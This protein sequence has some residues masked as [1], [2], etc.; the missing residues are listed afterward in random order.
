M[1][2]PSVECILPNIDNSI[3]ILYTFQVVLTLSTVT[4]AVYCYQSITVKLR[5]RPFKVYQFESNE[6]I[7]KAVQAVCFTLQT[8]KNKFLV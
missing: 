4:N 6:L 1:T 3:R 7:S 5:K 2:Y 8:V